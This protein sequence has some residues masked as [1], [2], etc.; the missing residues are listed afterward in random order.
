[1]L[2]GHPPFCNHYTID[3]NVSMYLSIY[4]SI[5]LSTYLPIYLSYPVLSCPFVLSYPILLFLL[6]YLI[7][8]VLSILSILSYPILPYLTLSYLSYLSHLISSHLILSV[9]RSFLLSVCLSIYLRICLS[10]FYLSA[11]VS[12]RPSMLE[13]ILEILKHPSNI[14]IFSVMTCQF[15]VWV[16]TEYG[17]NYI[18]LALI[19]T[20]RNSMF[21]LRSLKC[22]VR[23]F[24]KWY[25]N[26]PRWKLRP[27]SLHWKPGPNSEGCESRLSLE[28]PNP[29][30]KLKM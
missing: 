21:R 8:S 20:F 10:T 16:N 24:P 6:S 25:Q 23:R 3:R 27:R 29:W 5:Y 7:L 15:L 26:L 11:T 18:E 2:Y 22:S 13:N 14:I 4:P 12:M 9:Y 30:D 19:T 28:S 17:Q 1:M